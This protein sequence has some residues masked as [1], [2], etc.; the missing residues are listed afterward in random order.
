VRINYPHFTHGE[1]QTQVNFPVTTGLVL[2]LAHGLLLLP[3]NCS[4]VLAKG[5][6]ESYMPALLENR[7]I[8]FFFLK[9]FGV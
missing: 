7:I 3:L 1:R 9:G 4:P 5:C 6:I 2:F 8:V